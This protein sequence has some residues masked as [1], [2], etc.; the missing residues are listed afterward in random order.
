MFRCKYFVFAFL[1]PISACVSAGKNFGGLAAGDSEVTC[2]YR[3]SL[4]SIPNIISNRFA[5][6]L[7]SACRC[8]GAHH[9]SQLDDVPHYA[10]VGRLGN[11]ARWTGRYRS[12]E[13][14]GHPD[15]EGPERLGQRERQSR[16]MVGLSVRGELLRTSDLTFIYRAEGSFELHYAIP[17]TRPA[18]R[19]SSLEEES[20][21]RLVRQALPYLVHLRL[22]SRLSCHLLN[23][24]QQLGQHRPLP[25]GHACQ[26]RVSRS[27]NM[28]RE[29]F[30]LA[31]SKRAFQRRS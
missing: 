7:K 9:A 4:F 16:G 12:Q 21:L 13:A 22:K 15:E 26:C 24:Y 27:A 17:T 31:L 29:C 1:S 14:A 25:L 30:C 28:Q 10:R 6:H 18:P 19:P 2:T 5:P 3:Y 23:R 20:Q 8:E 11:T